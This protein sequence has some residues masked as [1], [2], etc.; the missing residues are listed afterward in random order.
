MTN[1][2]PYQNFASLEP[3]WQ[4]L[5]HSWTW[6]KQH[7]IVQHHFSFLFPEI[8]FDWN[9]WP[10]MHACNKW[11]NLYTPYDLRHL[12]HIN[13]HWWWKGAPPWKLCTPSLRWE[14]T[15]SV[16]YSKCMPN[17][18]IITVSVQYIPTKHSS[19][20]VANHLGRELIQHRMESF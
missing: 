8:G 17:P 3:F 14:W 16:Q 19:V 6:D 11:H 9:G 2:P 5:L 18:D 4:L 20:S 10:L 12:W 13:L 7:C 15:A 1:Q